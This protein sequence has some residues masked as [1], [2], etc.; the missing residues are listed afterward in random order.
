VLALVP[1]LKST[2]VV[3]IVAFVAIAAGVLILIRR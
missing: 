1:A 2:M 3:M